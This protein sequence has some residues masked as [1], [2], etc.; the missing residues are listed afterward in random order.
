MYKADDL[1]ARACTRSHS[2]LRLRGARA[3]RPVRRSNQRAPPR[4]GSIQTHSR[5]RLRPASIP[6]L[7][8]QPSP[9]QSIPSHPIPFRSAP[10]SGVAWEAADQHDAGPREQR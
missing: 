2:S 6:T 7:P 3:R 9:I 8:P 10:R 4:P 5:V 1:R